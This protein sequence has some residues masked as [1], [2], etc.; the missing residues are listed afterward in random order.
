M[1]PGRITALWVA[2]AFVASL[3]SACGGAAARRSGLP[4]SSPTNAVSI[5]VAPEQPFPNWPL[6][7][8]DIERLVMSR[9]MVA[10]GLARAGGTTGARKVEVHVVSTGQ[11]LAFKWKP[12]QAKPWYAFLPGL[13]GR[14]DGINN[15]P[16]K[17]IAAWKIQSLF[18]DP[19]EYV[20]P[21]AVPFC[22]S[23]RKYQFVDPTAHATAE[24]TDCELGVLAA[25][26]IDVEVPEALFD[27][28]RFAS[29]PVYAAYLADFNLLTYLIAH[30]D[31]RKGNFLVARDP[32]RR[33][34]FA[35][36]NGVSFGGIFYNWFVPNWNDIRVPGLRKKS[37]DRLRKIDK[38]AL[39][40]ALGTVAE[41]HLNENRIYENVD[42]GPTLDEDDGV[43]IQGDVLQFGLTDDEI[44]DVEERIDDLLEDVDDGKLPVF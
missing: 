43:R 8:Q 19:S 3:A 30:R 28:E 16:R 13:P 6:P 42:P 18:L 21:T 27:P 31:G 5:A 15:S 32:K 2:T 24:G 39:R 37:V 33:Q 11:K 17:E 36:D 10:E 38:N 26:L 34:V 23:V 7:P 44:E 4:Q 12:M 1:R 35:I 9:D 41:L 20:V 25:W 14:L 22:A 40:D 29:D